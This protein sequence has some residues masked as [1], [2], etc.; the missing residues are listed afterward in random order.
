MRHHF[1][2]LGI[3]QVRLGQ[4]RDPTL[5]GQQA[6]DVEVLA[7]LRLDGLVGGDHQQHQ[8]DAADAGQHVAD[9]ALVAGNIDKADADRLA[10][11]A[12]QIQVGK[13][14]ID[15]DA[16]A[17]FFF[18]AVGVDAGQGAHQ[19]ALAVVD[20]AG[21]ADNDGFH[22]DQ[23]TEEFVELWGQQKRRIA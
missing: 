4:N 23:C 22:S 12:G 21:G 13:A 20:V 9:E 14:D 11:R 2:R 16:A 3:D 10:R 19:R 5:H 18:Q 8:V 7:S 1:Q 15:G 17:L 6:A